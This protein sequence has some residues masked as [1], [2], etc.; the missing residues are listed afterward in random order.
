MVTGANSG[1]DGLQ[2]S[3]AYPM[4]LQRMVLVLVFV[5]LM[6]LMLRLLPG[7]LAADTDMCD[8]SRTGHA[9][10]KMALLVVLLLLLHPG[11][12]HQH[13]VPRLCHKLAGCPSMCQKLAGSHLHLPA[14]A[15]PRQSEQF[16]PMA[17]SPI[18]F[19]AFLL[20]LAVSRL[21]RS[22]RTCRTPMR[23]RKER[24]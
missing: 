15:L 14:A 3:V 2:E 6:M 24:S 22:T 7:T 21:V 8:C 11:T 19:L 13:P 16:L 9:P 4:Q 17:G 18:Q 23:P 1:L 12:C 20:V 5:L 10:S